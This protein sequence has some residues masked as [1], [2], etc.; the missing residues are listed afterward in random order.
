MAVLADLAQRHLAGWLDRQP[1]EAE[2]AASRD[3][4]LAMG[5]AR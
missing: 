2:L 3:R 4:A 1:D 5:A